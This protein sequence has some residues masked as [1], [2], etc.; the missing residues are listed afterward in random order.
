VSTLAALF[1]FAVQV[2]AA[3][4]QTRSEPANQHSVA[5]DLHWFRKFAR[6]IGRTFEQLFE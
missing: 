2:R 5:N 1:D 3:H 6:L 4:Y